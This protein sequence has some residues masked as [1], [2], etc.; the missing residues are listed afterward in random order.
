MRTVL[1]IGIGP[2]DPDYITVQAINA[3]RRVD[4]FFVTDKG[5]TKQDL[6]HLRR[7]ICERYLAGRAYRTIEIQDPERN[8]TA[9]DYLV[10]VEDW[11]NDRS[12]IYERLISSELNE[13]QCG[14]FL[15]WGDPSVY[16]STLRIIERITIRGNVQFHYEV[17][18]GIC[19]I[20]ALAAKHRI[21]L[22]QIGE[23]V[24]ITTGRRLAASMSMEAPDVVVMLDGE[25]AFKTLVDESIDIYWAAYLGTPDEILLSGRLSELAEKI[26]RVREEARERKGWIMDTYLLR[27]SPAPNER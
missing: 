16:D 11:H 12:T 3:L 27:K 26:E 2:G 1:V 21:T 5:S 13:D 24:Q 14:A 10:A 9:A 19:S 20:Q 4:V 18:P 8:R 15:V 6:L 22:N 7:E 23:S 25:C 17:I